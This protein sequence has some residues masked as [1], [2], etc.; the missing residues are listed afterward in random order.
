MRIAQGVYALAA[1][2]AITVALLTG[3]LSRDLLFAAVFLIGCARAFE[4]PTGHSLVPALVPARH[5]PRAVAA[6]ASAN[7]VAVICGPALGGLIY[8]VEPGA[9]ERH[10]ARV[11]HGVGIVL[12]SWS[13]RRTSPPNAR[14]ADLRPRSLAGFEFI[15]QRRG[16]SASSRSICSSSLLGGATALLPI[17]ARTSCRRPESAS[18][19]CAR[20]RRSARSPP[21]CLL[22]RYPVE[23]HIGRKMFAVVAIYGL[24]TIA[25]RCRPGCRCRCCAGRARRLR[26]RAA[27]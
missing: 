17:Y 26:R 19:C 4:M 5:V 22:S 20:R 24:A 9:G 11:L 6:W 3:T 16:C 15:R 13:R 7:Q 25:S 10:C 12:V 2:L 21:R 1:A 23:R 27:W 14:A 18:A 8:A